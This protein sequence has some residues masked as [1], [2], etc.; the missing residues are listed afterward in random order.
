MK[1]VKRNGGKVAK[2][3]F[4]SGSESESE[5]DSVVGGEEASIET[6]VLVARRQAV[7]LRRWWRGGKVARR[8]AVKL[9]RWWQGGK[10]ARR[11][12]GRA[13][14]EVKESAALWWLAVLMIF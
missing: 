12:G 3:S 6:E 8:Q 1:V 14:L 5:L 13:A 9:R 11:L 4:I 10:V 2:R 7:K